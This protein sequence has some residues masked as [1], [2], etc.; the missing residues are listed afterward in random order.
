M[1]LH[2]LIL[3]S[4]YTFGCVEGCCSASGSEGVSSSSDVTVFVGVADCCGLT[5][6][7]DLAT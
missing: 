3:V 5:R 2:Q 7:C 6:A 1:A 4:Y